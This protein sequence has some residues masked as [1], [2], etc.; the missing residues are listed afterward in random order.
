MY[1][2]IIMDLATGMLLVPLCI[3]PLCKVSSSAQGI[4][5]L[6]SNI[7]SFTTYPNIVM[8]LKSLDIEASIKVLEKY[9]KELN[10]KNK[11]RTME[12]CINSLKE[13]IVDI[14]KELSVI[15]E[16]L[17]YNSTVKYL[18]YFRT[19]KFVSSIDNLTMLKNQLDNRTK[20]FFEILKSNNILVN[21]IN[22]L[23][24][25]ISVICEL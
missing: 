7:T 20:L 4:Y 15:H 11:S 6:M 25:E 2:Y 22:T 16:K 5:S 10:L 18:T 21:N 17:A 19:Y 13:C 14:E 1:L 9:L 3:D 12:Q 8:A 24:P 23:D